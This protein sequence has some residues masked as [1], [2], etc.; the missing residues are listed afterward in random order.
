LNFVLDEN[1]PPAFARALDALRHPDAD[2]VR[3]VR[4]HVASGTSDSEWIATI[5]KVGAD[6]AVLSGDRR[7]I[8]R[9]HELQALR[10]AKLTTFILAK[11]WS[12]LKFWDKAWLLVRWWP[13]IVEL[14]CRHKA[15]SIFVVPYV[16]T[17][18]DLDPV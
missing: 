7:M 11:G 6:H 15:G 9:K 17:P 8:T 5:A 16:Q 13:K 14:A 12:R 1:L 10:D 2:S 3:T 18:K 4:D